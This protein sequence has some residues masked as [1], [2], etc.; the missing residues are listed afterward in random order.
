MQKIGD[1]SVQKIFAQN[2][3]NA[4]IGETDRQNDY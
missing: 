2:S 1:K 4:E 3:R